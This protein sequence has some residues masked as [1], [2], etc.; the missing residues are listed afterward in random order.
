MD[1]VADINTRKFLNLQL[2]VRH[3][4]WK[5]SCERIYQK[6]NDKQTAVKFIRCSASLAQ[7]TLFH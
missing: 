5:W 2:C 3:A 6:S 7:E 1:V 4:T